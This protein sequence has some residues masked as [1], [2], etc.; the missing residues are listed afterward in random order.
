[1]KEKETKLIDLR[2]EDWDA[3]FNWLFLWYNSEQTYCS[4]SC[5]YTN[6]MNYTF[7]TWLL[8]WSNS[9]ICLSITEIIFWP[10][11]FFEIMFLWGA[12]E[13]KQKAIIQES[14]I[15]YI[16]YLCNHK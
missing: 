4:C 15:D 9:T 7:K 16:Y 11:N 6:N 10:S 3:E 13:Y 14:P 5:H 12:K 8:D 1:M 2:L